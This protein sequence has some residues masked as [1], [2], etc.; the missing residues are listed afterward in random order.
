MGSLISNFKVKQ[1]DLWEMLRSYTQYLTSL[2]HKCVC[3]SILTH[4]VCV[5]HLNSNI[6]NGL[7]FKRLDCA[8]HYKIYIKV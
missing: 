1:T 3:K 2:I 4:K 5:Y 6:P 7:I 8:L